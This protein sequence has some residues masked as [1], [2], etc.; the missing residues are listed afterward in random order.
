VS[1]NPI[2]FSNTTTTTTTNNKNNNETACTGQLQQSVDVE[3]MEN[4]KSFDP[5]SVR[6][7]LKQYLDGNRHKISIIPKKKTH[8]LKRATLITY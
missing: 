4:I 5:L 2:L 1:K 7:N 8:G 3:K 6:I